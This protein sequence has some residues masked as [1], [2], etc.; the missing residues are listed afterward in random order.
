MYLKIL[1]DNFSLVIQ[2]FFGGIAVFYVTPLIVKSVGIH[3]YGNLA[4]MFAIVTYISLIIQ[5]SF[6]LIGP[7][8]IA[9]GNCKKTFNIILSAKLVLF[10]LSLAIFLLYFFFFQSKY[11]NVFLLF[12]ILPLSWVL[13]NSWFLQS[14]GYFILSSICSIIGSLVTFVIAYFFI[15]ATVG[16]FVPILCLILSSF[17]NG[18]LTFFF[19]LKKIGHVKI[20]NPLPI[21]KTGFPLFASQIVSSVYTM[22][23]VFIITHF[24]GVTSAG[25]YAVVERFMNLLISLGILTHVAAYPKLARLFNKDRLEYRKTLLFVVALYTFFS[26]CVALGVFN[27]HQDIV[28][29][30]FGSENGNAN[31]LIYSACI[32]IFVSIFGPVVTGYL[33]LKMEGKSIIIINITIALL[34]LLAGVGM[35]KIMGNSG[36]LIGLSLAQLLYIIIFFK[37]FI[38][39]RKKCVV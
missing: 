22:S 7:K 24:Y 5:Y 17:I 27:F 10:I 29:Y 32:Y 20:I 31:E 8:L 12:F 39:G 2:Y 18:S 3:S 16:L 19:A 25:T 13:N 1:I 23:G 11:D 26:C 15:N 9:E 35:L 33:A 4:I 6:N 14:K 34:S 36:W 30:M 37:I 28:N 21:L 38:W